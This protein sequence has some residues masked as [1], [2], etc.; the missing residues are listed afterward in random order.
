MHIC[1]ALSLSWGVNDAFGSMSDLNI[2]MQAR[3]RDPRIYRQRAKIKIA[4]SDARG[5]INDYTQAMKLEP[6][7]EDILF[8][9]I[10]ARL[11]IRDYEGAV[12]R[13]K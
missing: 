8:E 7:N 2:A 5:A 10:E 6:G 12:S 4:L 11:S 9:R 13:Y 3:P 1:I